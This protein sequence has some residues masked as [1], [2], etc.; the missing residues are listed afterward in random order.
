VKNGFGILMEIALTLQITFC[1]TA[2][3]TILIL[4]IHEHGKSFYLLMSSS[5]SFSNV[6][7]FHCRGL[8]P[9]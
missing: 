2:I 6:L 3:F 8:S 1:N 5:I 9:A 4:L 7:Y